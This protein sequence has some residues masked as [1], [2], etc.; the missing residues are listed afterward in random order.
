[1]FCDEHHVLYSS[2]SR[3]GAPYFETKLR[4]EG[5][6][7]NFLELDPPPPPPNLKKIDK[8]EIAFFTHEA[9]RSSYKL[10]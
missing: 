9:L 3:G 6:K 10:V 7:K 1:M 4:P 2:G 5:L 8:L